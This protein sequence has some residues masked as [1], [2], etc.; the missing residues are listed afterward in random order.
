MVENGLSSRQET[1]KEVRTMRVKLFALIPIVILF[2]GLAIPV[3]GQTVTLMAC[4]TIL[5][6]L[7]RDW[8]ATRNFF[9]MYGAHHYELNPII[10]QIGPDLYFATWTI[11]ISALCK[12]TP[13]WRVISVLVW[14]AETF[15]VGSHL[16]WGTA[17]GMPMLR[18]EVRW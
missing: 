16:P 2:V 8:D 9:T 13:T 1:G 3:H 17:N 4:P 12:E 10:R 18:F 5:N 14:A 11:G 7:E 15:A 6:S